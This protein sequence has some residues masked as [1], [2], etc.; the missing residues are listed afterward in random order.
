VKD[1]LVFASPAGT[2]EK[3]K[4]AL[5]KSSLAEG[6]KFRTGSHFALEIPLEMLLTGTEPAPLERGDSPVAASLPAALI[7]AAEPPAAIAPAAIAPAAAGESPAVAAAA[8]PE[9]KKPNQP[10]SIEDLNR[11]IEALSKEQDKEA[12]AK[13]EKEVPKKPG[14]ASK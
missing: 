14:E 11:A 2:I 4:L 7:P 9:T 13:G 6:A 10:P 3:L 12:K 8:P 1:V 5:A